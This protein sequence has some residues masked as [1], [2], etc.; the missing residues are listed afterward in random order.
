M[1]IKNEKLERL[2]RDDRANR[3][4]SLISTTHLNMKNECEEKHTIRVLQKKI[5]DVRTIRFHQL[6]FSMRP[7][8]MEMLLKYE[9]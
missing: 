3:R 7:Q 8:R 6:N 9:R 5:V 4:I 1:K 2:L